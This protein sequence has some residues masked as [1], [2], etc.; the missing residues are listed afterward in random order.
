MHL[1]SLIGG[2]RRRDRKIPG[3]AHWLTSF[4]KP[5]RSRFSERSLSQKLENY[6]RR[7]MTSTSAL[8]IH[9]HFP[10][11][12]VHT[13]P[14]IHIHSPSNTKEP[15][16]QDCNPYHFPITSELIFCLLNYG[17]H[18][19]TSKECSHKSRR[20]S[21]FWWYEDVRNTLWLV[22]CFGKT[23]EIK[24]KTVDFFQAI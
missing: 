24:R 18:S 2:C 22:G 1:F 13:H 11:P 8:Y 3:R 10:N 9:I 23:V 14:Q 19:Q 20:V 16:L 7:Q 6:C 15:V 12:H 5:M 21:V 17:C 4:A